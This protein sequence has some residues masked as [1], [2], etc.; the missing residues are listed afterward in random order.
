MTIIH[1]ANAI[2]VQDRKL[3]AVREIGKDFFIAPGGTVEAGETHQLTL[4]REL[5][6]ELNIN[7][8]ESNLTPYGMFESDSVN[9]PG[10]S[11]RMQA[12]VVK[13]WNGSLSPNEEIEEYRWLTSKYEPGV[14][15]GLIFTHQIIPRLKERGL[16]E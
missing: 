12:F 11:V 5:K 10:R 3:L 9:H 8:S 14:R 7:V 15:V 2:I 6:E 1:T 4:I 16:I 13:D